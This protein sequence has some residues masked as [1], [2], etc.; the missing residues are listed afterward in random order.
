M[1]DA[2][3]TGLARSGQYE[4]ALR[5]FE[6]MRSSLVQPTKKTREIIQVLTAKVAPEGTA[7]VT[8]TKCTRSIVVFCAPPLAHYVPLHASSWLLFCSPSKSDRFSSL[9]C[10][11]CDM[12]VSLGLIICMKSWMTCAS[13]DQVVDASI[14]AE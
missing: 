10:L 4:R 14:V 5:V 7:Y 8:R 3:L 2:V 9:Q 13:I 11:L 6:S 12:M 1:Y